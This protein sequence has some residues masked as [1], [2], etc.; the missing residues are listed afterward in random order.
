MFSVALH[1]IG[2]ELGINSGDIDDGWELEPFH[3]GG[4]TNVNI[5]ETNGDDGAHFELPMSLMNPAVP[6]NV[7]VLPSAVDVLGVAWDESFANVD[8]LRKHFIGGA[9]GE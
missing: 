9:H 7:R 4:T 1:E 5:D 6:D 8:L 2:H 3:I